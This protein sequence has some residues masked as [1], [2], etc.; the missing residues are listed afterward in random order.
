MEPA[1]HAASSFEFGV[2]LES[3]NWGVSKISSAEG[4]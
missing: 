2:F 1:L 4:D 3:F